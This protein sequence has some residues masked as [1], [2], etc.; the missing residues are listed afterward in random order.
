MRSRSQRRRTAFTLMEVMLV[1]GILAVLA[2]F[3]IP[4]LMGRATKVKIDLAKS[5]VARGG[6][7][8]KALNDYKWDLGKFPDT[9]EGLPALYQPKER[10]K[11]DEK[12]D[13][14]YMEGAFEELKDPWNNP[15]EYRSPGEMNE[16]SYDLWSHGPDGKDDGGKEGSDDIKNWI[17]K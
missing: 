11:E 17:E 15:Y 10:K 7:I 16:E 14:P 12:Y 2:A 3:A 5:Q 1:A 6:N 13:G 4:S 9:D 8:A